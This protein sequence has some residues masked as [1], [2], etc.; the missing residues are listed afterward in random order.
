MY[1]YGLGPLNHTVSAGKALQGVETKTK[2]L[3][4]GTE[5][6]NNSHNFNTLALSGKYMI[7]FTKSKQ[8]SVALVAGPNPW[9]VDAGAGLA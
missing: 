7:I 5:E 1:P 9:R 6:N 4:E 2:K 3:Q 8:N